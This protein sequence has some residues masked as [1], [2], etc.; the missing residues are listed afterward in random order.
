MGRGEVFDLATENRKAVAPEIRP[1]RDVPYIYG[2]ITPVQ[3]NE[4]IIRDAHK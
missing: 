4:R 2:N 3:K 1:G